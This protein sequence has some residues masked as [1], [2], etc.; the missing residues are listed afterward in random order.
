M[1]RPVLLTAGATR[2]PVDAIRYLSAH[3][4]GRTGV[5]LAARLRGTHDV[6]L[7]GS[8]EACLR[9]RL[10]GLAEARLEE[11]MGTRDLMARVEAHLRARP[12][13]VLIHSAAVGDYEMEA[14]RADKIPSGADGIELRLVRAPKIVDR[15]REWAPG[16]FLVSFKAAPPSTDHDALER[17]A[18]AQLARTG[19]DLVFANA[20]GAIERDVLL[21]GRDGTRAFARRED[22]VSALLDAVRAA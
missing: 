10:S 16:C 9:A 19:S 1:P 21:V 5:D 7:L 11:F 6:T 3:A 13:S 8:A 14:P 4:T 17:I 20:L 18:R 15:V 12:D 2:N 22:A